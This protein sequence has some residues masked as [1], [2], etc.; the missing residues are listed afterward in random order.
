VWHRSACHQFIFISDNVYYIFYIL[1]GTS[2]LD[3]DFYGDTLFRAV[4]VDKHILA[5]LDNLACVYLSVDAI[6]KRDEITTEF[7]PLKPASNHR[8]M[9]RRDRVNFNL[10]LHC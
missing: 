7:G 10:V 4:L 2:N 9:A 5:T 8:E 3:A 6:E 1:E